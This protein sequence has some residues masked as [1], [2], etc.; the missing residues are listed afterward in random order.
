MRRVSQLLDNTFTA[1]LQ[2]CS[3]W[4]APQCNVQSVSAGTCPHFAT[5]H[6]ES[7]VSNVIFL[8][9]SSALKMSQRTVTAA[10]VMVQCDGWEAVLF[11]DKYLDIR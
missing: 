8:V 9:N 4:L 6:F 7:N 1:A 2:H 11:I 3:P 5:K 10:G